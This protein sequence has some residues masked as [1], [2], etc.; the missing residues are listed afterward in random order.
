MHSLK[1][2]IAF[3]DAH[4]DQ[5]MPYF[6]QELLVMAE[7]KGPLTDAE[8]HRGAGAQPSVGASAR[9]RCDDDEIQARCALR[10]DRRT[11]RID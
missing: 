7:Q 9:H 1:D 6:G 11:G 4:K 2:I 3:N 10:A 5:E 8:V